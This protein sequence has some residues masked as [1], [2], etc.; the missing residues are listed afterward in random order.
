MKY[1]YLFWKISSQIK[2]SQ[3]TLLKKVTIIIILKYI[4][5]DYFMKINQ[6][7]FKLMIQINQVSSIFRLN[8]SI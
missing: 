8:E 6:V 2:N 5:I 3:N 1:V 4:I 7:S